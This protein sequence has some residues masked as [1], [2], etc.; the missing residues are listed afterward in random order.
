MVVAACRRRRRKE[1]APHDRAMC[2]VPVCLDGR[3]TRICQVCDTPHSNASGGA[4]AGCHIEK[5]PPHPSVPPP[6][7]LSLSDGR[8][9][10]VPLR[11]KHCRIG[12]LN[13]RSGMPIGFPP[14]SLREEARGQQPEFSVRRV[15]TI[16]VINAI[17]AGVGTK[18]TG[19]TGVGIISA[20][21]W[22]ARYEWHQRGMVV[23]VDEPNRPEARRPLAAERHKNVIRS[24]VS[25]RSTSDRCPRAR[26]AR[27]G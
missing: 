7:A 26:V 12:M 15:I 6:L 10:V 13:D 17:R 5:L 8:G 14:L 22:Q 18:E 21:R 25:R 19:L 27:S 9:R 2:F 23:D 1:R 24:L 3:A 11:V 20:R 16:K 4:F